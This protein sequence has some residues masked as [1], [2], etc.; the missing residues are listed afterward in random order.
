MESIAHSLDD[1]QLMG[2][3]FLAGRSRMTDGSSR[4]HSGLSSFREPDVATH[5]QGLLTDLCDLAGFVAYFAASSWLNR[6]VIRHGVAAH[7]LW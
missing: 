3:R 7:V 4:T 1:G 6:R 2:V 5:G